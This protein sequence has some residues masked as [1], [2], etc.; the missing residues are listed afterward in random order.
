MKQTLLNI[1]NPIWNWSRDHLNILIVIAL[2][3]VLFLYGGTHFKELFY[4]FLR[5]AVVVAS[6]TT[7]IDIRMKG[8]LRKYIQSG[9]F[10]THFEA[11]PPADKVKWTFVI[12]GITIAVA[13]ICFIAP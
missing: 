5:F 9:D 13:A 7:L 3:V 2:A 12:L 4:G 10:M 1:W 11:L 6:A 8:T